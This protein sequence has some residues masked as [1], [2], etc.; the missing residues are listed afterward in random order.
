MTSFLIGSI[1]V[2]SFRN[3]IDKNN[4]EILLHYCTENSGTMNQSFSEIEN[5]VDTL[6]DYYTEQIDS[7]DDLKDDA[8]LAKYTK[9]TGEIAYSII[10]NNHSIVAT[11]FR[12][13]PEITNPSAVFFISRTAHA[14]S[15][16]P[17]FKKPTDLSK[18]DSSDVQNVGW[19]HIPVKK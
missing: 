4:H 11:Y 8:F 1:A 6:S 2:T 9:K 10:Q 12:F 13:N 7:S 14:R 3:V 15:N 17:E 5:L 18:Y 19:Y 16:T